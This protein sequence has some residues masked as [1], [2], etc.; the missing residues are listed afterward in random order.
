M[1]NKKFMALENDKYESID[2][3]LQHQLKEA[4]RKAREGRKEAPLGRVG[5]KVAAKAGKMARKKAAEGGNNIFYVLLLIALILDL[6]EY[7]DLGTLTT[8]VNIGAYVIVAV[9]GFVVWFIKS[10]GDN[11]FSIFNLLKGQL[12]KYL[13]L[14]IFEW[15]PIINVLPFWTGTVVMMWVRFSIAKRKVLAQEGEAGQEE[16]ENLQEEYA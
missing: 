10:G 12:W 8:L 1:K 16:P 9:G 13:I 7:L 14:P 11:K 5:T 3:R 6:I 15:I 4:R 2:E